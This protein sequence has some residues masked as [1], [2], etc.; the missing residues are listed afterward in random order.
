MS[1]SM[2]V[3]NLYYFNDCICACVLVPTQTLLARQ[4]CICWHAHILCCYL[5]WCQYFDIWLVV[6][7]WHV[8]WHVFFVLTC[9]AYICSLCWHVLCHTDDVSYSIFD[10]FPFY[11]RIFKCMS[12]LTRLPFFLR[13]LFYVGLPFP[14]RVYLI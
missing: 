5:W 10:W 11:W 13:L 12:L 3:V 2:I 7:C 6:W 4:G 14:I 1:S 8:L 9:T